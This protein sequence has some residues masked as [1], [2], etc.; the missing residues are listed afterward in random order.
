MTPYSP[1]EWSSSGRNVFGIYVEVIKCGVVIETIQ[2]PCTKEQSYTMAGRTEGVCDLVL[3]H[4]SISRTHAV[5]QFDEQGALF[6]YDMHSTHG[7]FVNKKRI[8]AEEFVR[9]HIGDVVGFGESMRLYAI[10]GPPELLPAEYESLNLVKFRERLETKVEETGASWG[11]GNDAEDEESEEEILDDKMEEL[12]DYLRN[13]KE[14]DLPYTSRV[15]PSQVNAKD[16][17]LFQQLQTRIRK[18]E[19]LRIEKGRIL[20]K[21]NRLDGLTEGQQKTLERNELRIETLLKEI[22]DLEARIEAKTEQ[23]TKSST[24]SGKK[25]GNRQEELYDYNSDEDDFYDRTS[26]NQHKIAARKQKVTGR[27][28]TIHSNSNAKRRTNQVLT[29]ESIHENVMKLEHELQKIQGDLSIAS[30]EIVEKQGFQHQITSNR[31]DSLDSFMTETTTQLHANKVDS[32]LKHKATIETALKRQQHLLVVATP[33][34]SALPVV[35]TLDNKSMDKPVKKSTVVAIAPV[36][37]TSDSNKLLNPVS[38]DECKT[39]ERV[40]SGST[41]EK[42]PMVSSSGTIHKKEELNV[43]KRRRVAGPAMPIKPVQIESI[44][45]ELI[46]RNAGVLEGGDHVWVPPTNQTGDGRTKLNEKLGY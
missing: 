39:S 35:Q 28:T 25:T 44:N 23:R 46:G 15:T 6:L 37:F 36:T 31:E 22:E 24:G 17:R 5:L 42:R 10:C 21:Q 4:P 12:P 3:A 40:C 19:N 41:T 18:M 38:H 2:L 13:F 45:R 27:I 26:A 32:L 9:L 11:F 43:L 1:P 16:E 29:A 20:A 30:K 7:C 8:P 34:L 33:A 14:D